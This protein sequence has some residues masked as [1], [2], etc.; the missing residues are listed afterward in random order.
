MKSKIYTGILAAALLGL[1][2]C[3]DYLDMSPTD[4]VSD[5]TVWSSVSGAEYAVNYFY[6]LT[7]YFSPY[8]DDTDGG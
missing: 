2:S 1:G 4:E 5:I 7:D 3:S 8:Y 6:G